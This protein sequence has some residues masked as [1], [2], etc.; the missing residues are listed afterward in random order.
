MKNLRFEAATKINGLYAIAAS[1]DYNAL[2]N[3]NLMTGEC[4]YLSMIPGENNIQMR[5]YSVALKMDNRVYFVPASAR[6]IAVYDLE[7]GRVE[8]IDYYKKKRKTTACYKQNSNFNGAVRFGKYIFMIPFTFPG[9]LRLDTENNTV[10]LYDS[11]IDGQQ[12]VFKKEPVVVGDKFYIPSSIN[13]LVLEFDMNN[14]EGHMFAVGKHNLGCWSMFYNEG[15][16]WFSPQEN[17]PIIS[18]NMDNDDVVEYSNYPKGFIGNGFCFT[19]I[20]K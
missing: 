11:W 16:M 9:V 5:L 18:W 15:I 20:Y 12:F 4:R 17:G 3:V 19:K 6:E 8:K 13:N 10:E 1:Y 2:F 14:C 7:N